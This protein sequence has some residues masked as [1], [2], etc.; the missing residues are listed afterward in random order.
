[1]ANMSINSSLISQPVTNA[2]E[3]IFGFLGS[4]PAQV[5]QGNTVAII[6]ALILFYIL[7]VVLQKISS[8]L[9]ALMKRIIM[10]LIVGLV[11][12]D[13][14]PKYVQLVT[15]EGFTTMNIFIG[16]IAFSV[17]TVG[18]FVAFKAFL[19]SAKEHIYNFRHTDSMPK[20]PNNIQQENINQVFTKDSISNEKSLMTVLVYLIVAE[21]G[22]FS[23]PTLSAPSVQVGILFFIV[24]I[25]GLMIF[26]K[27]T[28]KSI[29]T[30]ALYFGAT[31][32]V[33]LLVSFLLGMMWGKSS[34]TELLSLDFFT[35]SSL[36]AT[37]TGMGVSLFAGSKG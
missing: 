11:I 12:L 28:Y 7:I 19:S 15:S 13:F 30:A 33:G 31:F 20:N 16:I 10:F 6:I 25:I 8:L 29:K 21:F 3:N 22:V 5:M 17:S 23:S 34:I 9:L 32:V 35:S 37:I 1:M 24:F 4:L 26:A 14:V 2:T 36:V 18:F 27:S